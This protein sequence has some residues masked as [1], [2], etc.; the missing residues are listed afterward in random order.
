[1]F[2]FNRSKRNKQTKLD[3]ISKNKQ[4]IIKE[5]NEKSLQILA[6]KEDLEL[7]IIASLEQQ[8][9]L[10]GENEYLRKLKEKLNELNKLSALTLFKNQQFETEFKYVKK[11]FS[12]QFEALNNEEINICAYFRLGFN[13]KEISVLERIDLNQIRFYKTC[14]K[15]KLNLQT[16]ASLKDFLIFEE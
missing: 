10:T 3:K 2:F 7:A 5:L 11:M 8:I 12:E 16:Q 6:K 15:R 4:E 9:E 1:M 14:I 13:T